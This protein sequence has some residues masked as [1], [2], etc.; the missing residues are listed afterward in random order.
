MLYEVIT[1][2]CE[3]VEHRYLVPFRSFFLLARL[4][5]LPGF[6]RRNR[7]IGYRRA[8]GHVARLGIRSEVADQYP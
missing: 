5:V 3:P 1:Y 6:A 2:L 7:Q 8:A 4:F